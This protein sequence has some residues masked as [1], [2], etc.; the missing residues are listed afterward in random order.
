LLTRELE[1]M[2]GTMFIAC[3]VVAGR[4]HAFRCCGRQ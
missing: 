2:R 4:R 3:L 1:R